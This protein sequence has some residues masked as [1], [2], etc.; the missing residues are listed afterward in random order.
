MCPTKPYG[1]I[2]MSSRLSEDV[3][4][5]GIQNFAPCEEIGQKKGLNTFGEWNSS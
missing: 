5:K 2:G 3:L 4:P 1:S